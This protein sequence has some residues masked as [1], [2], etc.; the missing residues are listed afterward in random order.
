MNHCPSQRHDKKAAIV[1]NGPSL[2]GFDFACK[3]KG[4]VSFG[5]N[6]AYRY[7]DVV[8]WYPDYYSCLDRV[9]GMAHLEDIERLVY[10]ASGYGIKGFLLRH[11]VVVAL[12]LQYNELVQD[13]DVLVAE[14]ASFFRG[15]WANTGSLSAAW[16]A[17]KGYRRL[18]LLGA[19][20]SYIKYVEGAVHMSELVLKVQTQPTSNPNYFFDDYQRK[21]DIYHVPMREH[22]DFP[23]EDQLLGWHMIR[24]Q[25]RRTGTLVVNASPDSH[26]SAFPRCRFEDAEHALRLA[27]RW[28]LRASKC[29]AL[30]AVYEREDGVVLNT[31]A[32]IAE[33]CGDNR[34]GAGVIVD[35]GAYHGA[36]ALPFL[37]R[38]WQVHAIEAD[39]SH[40]QTLVRLQAAYPKLQVEHV[41]MSCVAGR[42]YP[43]F[44]HV[45]H[46]SLHAMKGFSNEYVPAGEV[47]T[48]TIRKWCELQGITRIN[49]L[50][51]DVVGF[52]LMV[53]RG[54]DFEKSLPECIVC[55][56]ND[57]KSLHLGT[58]THDLG[59]FLLAYGYDV[60]ISEWY[61]ELDASLQ[62]QW[63]RLCPYPADPGHPAAWGHFLAFRGQLR[64]GRLHERLRRA[65]EQHVAVGAAFPP[66]P[67][68]PLHN[69][70]CIPYAIHY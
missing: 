18:V 70:E 39:F 41:A 61:P 15:Y 62:Q 60:Y 7:W 16:A 1:C 45:E 32:L 58:D 4:Y 43:W 20:A 6:L 30:S 56:W 38:G 29:K 3:L 47:A 5:M 24:P 50:L 42:K 53:L 35:I 66:S 34:R 51:C 9:V 59:S 8:G 28:E 69:Q 27:R 2:R 46:E 11:N 55:A 19:D 49:V 22:P 13:F 31:A 67:L 14:D 40:L 23:H 10:N 57:L 36:M 52:E 68:P 12:R 54:M 37:Q 26:I 48:N 63:K 44:H 17:M 25:L 33:M 64:T 65:L 21:G